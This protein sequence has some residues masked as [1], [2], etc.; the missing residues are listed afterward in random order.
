MNVQADVG[1]GYAD[2][3]TTQVQTI[4]SLSVEQPAHDDEHG[5]V[6][7]QDAA[8]GTVDRG[9]NHINDFLSVR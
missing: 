2:R 8:G 7:L 3:R 5:F 9:R 6:R 1:A 4:Q